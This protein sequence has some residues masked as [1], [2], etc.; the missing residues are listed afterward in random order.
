MSGLSPDL[1]ALASR[2]SGLTPGERAEALGRIPPSQQHA[3]VAAIMEQPLLA[4]T[5]GATAKLTAKQIEADALLDGPC[6]H[7]LLV[8]GSRSGKT[9][10]IVRKLVQRALTAP[11]RQA[12]LRFRFNSL[13]ASIIGDTLPAVMKAHFPGAE[14]KLDKQLWVARFAN[15]SEIWFS[16][17][18]E[19]DR[20][21]KVLGQ[22]HAGLYFNESSQIP[23]SSRQV[24]ITRLAQVVEGVPQKAYYDANPP[25]RRS[26]LYSLFIDKVDPERH[27]RL[28][29]PGTFG[30]LAMNPHDNRENLTAEYLAD[31]DALDERR[32]NRFFLGLWSDD[33]ENALW[34]P[35]ML[36]NG[37]LVNKE[38]PEMQRIVIGV[39][40]TGCSGPEDLRSDEVGIVV[41]GLA[42]D[43]K[44][45]VI[46]D[47]SGR[48]G[49]DQWKTIVASA[50]DR[51]GA[52]AV[53]AETNYGG[54]M[55][56]EVLRT[57]VAEGGYPLNVK[58]VVASRGKH[59]RAEPIAA[60]WSQGRV[61]LA[62][63]FSDLEHQMLSMTTA[64][65]RGDRSPDRLDAMVWALTS[66]FPAMAREARDAASG[67]IGPRRRRDR[68]RPTHANMAYASMKPWARRG[69]SGSGGGGWVRGG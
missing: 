12:I 61:A 46:E 8:G 36:D 14:W 39:D 22:G 16:G 6:R 50:Y 2:L 54:Q 32:R 49:P 37:R 57:A 30:W 5:I 7:I 9:W 26:W 28:A 66:L 40:P 25:S 4:A 56:L 47:L 53:V 62:G 60:L 18:D 43:G 35:E 65:Y 67:G 34:R 55:V 69:G 27:Q 68:E 15:D 10:V 1:L 19:A 64:G 17:L 33:A 59:V 13:H 38:P 20:V 23:W 29:Q 48:F 21:E 31:L 24:A 58:E 63:R 45:Y 44:G 11:C 51:Y 42:T 52:D 3:I 41:C